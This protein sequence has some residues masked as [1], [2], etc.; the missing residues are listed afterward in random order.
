MIRGEGRGLL[1]VDGAVGRERRDLPGREIEQLQFD[2]I[3][4]VPREHDGA[5]IGRPVGLIIVDRA[6]G[7]LDGRVRRNPLPPQRSLHGVD[8]LGAVR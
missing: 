2:R 7:D 6:G 3:A 4:R 1:E 5:S 8:Q